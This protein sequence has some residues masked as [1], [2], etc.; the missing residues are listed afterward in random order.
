MRGAPAQGGRRAGDQRV[1][2]LRGP[3]GRDV[4]QRGRGAG[5]RAMPVSRRQHELDE[6]ERVLPKSLVK[7]QNKKQVLN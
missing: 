1:S 7:I 6:Q 3:G 2:R 4:G 5:H